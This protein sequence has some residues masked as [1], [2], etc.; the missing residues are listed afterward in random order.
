[1]LSVNGVEHSVNHSAEFSGVLENA[2]FQGAAKFGR[3]AK[4]CVWVWVCFT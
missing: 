3:V 4:G 1:M 2:V